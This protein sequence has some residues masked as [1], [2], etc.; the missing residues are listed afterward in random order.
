MTVPRASR[1][2]WPLLNGP[3]TEGPLPYEGDVYFVTVASSMR[4]SDTWFAVTSADFC[5]GL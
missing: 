4:T 5:C 3:L 1:W 2:R